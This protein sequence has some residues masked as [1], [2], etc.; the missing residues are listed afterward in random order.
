MPIFHINRGFFPVSVIKFS[1]FALHLWENMIKCIYTVNNTLASTRITDVITYGGKRCMSN[2]PTRD[3]QT[4][5]APYARKQPPG[6]H[7][8]PYQGR[9]YPPTP[10]RQPMPPRQTPAQPPV[11]PRV[12]PNILP[13]AETERLR[14]VP[15]AKNG[16]SVPVPSKKANKRKRK[17]SKERSVLGDFFL[18]FAVSLLVFGIAAIIVCSALISLFT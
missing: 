6:Q 14:P 18:A 12:K 15:P 13:R 2:I 3:R 17:E 16:K 9:Q 10:P 11:P 5:S 7:V 4:P 8:P 1:H